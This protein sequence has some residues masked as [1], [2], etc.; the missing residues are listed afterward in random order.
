MLRDLPPKLCSLML[1][2]FKLGA[3]HP[4]IHTSVLTTLARRAFYSSTCT[5]R[6]AMPLYT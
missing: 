3:L 2:L 1:L 4:R 6:A 5:P